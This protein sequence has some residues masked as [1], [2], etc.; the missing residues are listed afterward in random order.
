MSILFLFIFQDIFS[1]NPT[2]GSVYIKGI[3]DRER[4]ESVTLIVEVQDIFGD[5]NQTDSG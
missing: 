3:L 4:T 1:I 2:N 5:S